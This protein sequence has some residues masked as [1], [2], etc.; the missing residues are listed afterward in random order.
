MIPLPMI[1]AFKLAEPMH[2]L[3]ASRLEA[4]ARLRFKVAQAIAQGRML[5][6]FQPVVRAANPRF[7]AFFEM[8]ARLQLPDGQLLAAGAFVPVV[9][10]SE[11]G[12]ALDRA[13][14]RAGLRALA[15]APRLR[16]SVNVSPLSMGDEAWL[17]MLAAATRR[18]GGVCERLI[19]EVTETAA[20]RDP[21]QTRDFI[22]HVR[23]SGC[24]FALDDFGAGATGFRHFRDFR[25]DFVKIDGSFCRGVHAQRDAQVLVECLVGIARH[26]EMGT[27]AERIEDEADAIWLREQGI[28]CFQG[29]LYGRPEAEP[30]L[31]PLRE[32]S[33]QC[34]ERAEI[35][36]TARRVG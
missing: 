24:A 22:E 36:E 29:W 13:A 9:E 14:L 1:D 35:A 33:A 11:L 34:V 10:E 6:H 3:A 18:G 28:D 4:R 32:A 20:L 16:V 15:A 5:F 27:V 8:L 17:G 31:P 2:G 23:R 19:L 25:F 7:P 26:F 12:R 30:I 21:E